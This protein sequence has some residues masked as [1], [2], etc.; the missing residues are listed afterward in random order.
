MKKKPIKIKHRSYSLYNRKKSKAKQAL[1]IFITI[2]AAALLCVVG[3]GLGK[4]ITE[5]LQGKRQP[6]DI[7]QTSEA[8]QAGVT[9]EASSDTATSEPETEE[10]APEVAANETA[11]ILPSAALKNMTA[12]SKAVAQAKEAGHS[13]VMVTLKN[14][15]GRFLYASE[16][17]GVKG[18]DSVVGT[19][20]AKQISDTI[21]AAGLVPYARIST[22]KD[23]LASDYIADVRYTTSDG[24]TWMD[25]APANGG[26]SW[27][28]PFAKNTAG[29]VSSI[30]A[31]LSSAGFKGIVLADTIYPN[32]QYTD[33]AVYLSHMTGLDD[34]K[35]RQNAL[36]SVI[37]ACGRAAES[38]GAEIILELDANDLDAA[39][40]TATTAEFAADKEK[41][42]SVK[43]MIDLSIEGNHYP[44]AKS[45]AGK[46][47]ALYSGQEY[48]VSINDYSLT[49]EER[50][51]IV[52]AFD[53]A[54]ITVFMNN[55]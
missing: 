14:S 51:N 20:T 34:P 33:Y 9:A 45:F 40:K 2:F 55:S 29:F 38:N 49:D 26:K 36:W 47:S 8:S 11:Y 10:A 52:K 16:I 50:Q 41:L 7:V 22:L 44:S 39:D 17:D 30:V 21:T 1:A 19:L 32:F 4:P 42:K 53:E 23:P 35:T 43:L 24:W 54:K 46:M 5:Y 27:V 25:N 3:Y 28:S 31:E 6:A 15:T 18:M 13:I 48:S 12:L 37:S